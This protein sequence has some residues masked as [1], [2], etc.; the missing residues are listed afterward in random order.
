[1]GE[2]FGAPIGIGAAEQDMRQVAL[3]GLQAQELLGKIEQQPAQQALAEAHARLYGSEADLKQV[4]VKQ[5]QILQKLAED[6]ANANAAASQGEVYTADQARSALGGGPTSQAEPFERMLALA[7]KQNINP[8]MTEE[9]GK[10]AVAIRKDEAMTAYRNAQAAKQQIDA[11]HEQ[12]A[13]ASS[14][15]QGLLAGGPQNY[16]KLRASI[17]AQTP[18]GQPSGVDLL[19]EGFEEAK[20]FLQQFVVQGMKAKEWLDTQR[21]AAAETAKEA[22]WR[23]QTG[24]AGA[25]AALSGQRLKLAKQEFDFRAKNDGERSPSAA[26]A[27]ESMNRRRDVLNLKELDAAYPQAPADPKLWAEGKKY[28]IGDKFFVARKGSN[29]EVGGEPITDIPPSLLSLARKPLSKNAQGTAEADDDEGE[30]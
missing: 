10:R 17:I 26:Q 30:D 28:R 20:P 24:S 16:D 6:S 13:M 23:A 21:E 15:A 27:R 25:A 5:Q 22:L 7:T 3:G 14:Q 12:L 18:P 29:G 8:L 1:M 11:Q 19:P 4:Q 9:L 2:M